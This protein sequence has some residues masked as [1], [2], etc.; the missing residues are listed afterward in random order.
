MPDK[1]LMEEHLQ[2]AMYGTPRVNPD[3][4]R[5]Y[6]GTFRERV[7]L[8]MTIAEVKD[9]ANQS[10]FQT[11]M[12]AHPTYTVLLNGHLDQTIL[13]PYFQICGHNNLKFSLRMD[14]FYGSKPND[15]GLVVT[16]S[17]AINVAP[18]ALTKKYPTKISD[19]PP[20]KTQ[21]HR[22]WLTRLFKS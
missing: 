16:S 7:S 10:A 17:T 5:R 13:A 8:T 19:T 20:I 18:V 11:E 6:L 2:T 12:R 21:P 14:D 22:N 3:E 9:T 15:L 1:S 4:Q